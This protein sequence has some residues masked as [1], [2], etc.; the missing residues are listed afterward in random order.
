VPFEAAALQQKFEAFLNGTH[1][2]GKVIVKCSQQKD[3]A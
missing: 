3:I 1:N 2:A